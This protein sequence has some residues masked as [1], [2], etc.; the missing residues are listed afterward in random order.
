MYISGAKMAHTGKVYCNPLGVCYNGLERREG[1]KITLDQDPAY[2]ETEVIIHC[3]QADED[4]LRLV[5]ML[6]VYQKKLVGI[7]DGER[8]LLDVKDVLYIDTA[9]KKTFLYTEKAVYQS[10]L[11]LYELEETLREL[12]FF[13]AG[14]SA[15]LNF[16]RV[17]SVRPELGRRWLVTMDNGEQIW[18]SRQYAGEL[19]DKL[20]QAERSIFP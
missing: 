15:I 7:L 18:V 4:I 3:A 20:Q 16:R 19:K 9:D 1:M 14:R 8:H 11:R 2:R 17:K 13:R 12:D 6:R 5:A 10:A